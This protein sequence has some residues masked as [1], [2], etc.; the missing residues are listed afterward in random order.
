MPGLSSRTISILSSQRD[1]DSLKKPR[2]YSGTSMGIYGKHAV[3]RP[4]VHKL[5]RE[6]RQEVK[7]IARFGNSQVSI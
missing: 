2:D 5:V 6:S 1:R 3:A 7:L 4:N